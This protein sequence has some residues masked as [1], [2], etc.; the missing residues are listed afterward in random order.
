MFKTP[1]K[2]LVQLGLVSLF[3]LAVAGC[4]SVAELDSG[5]VKPELPQQWSTNKVG[6][7]INNKW[8]DSLINQAGNQSFPDKID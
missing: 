5:L 3:G 2:P 6:D 4:S 7:E 8:L 1:N